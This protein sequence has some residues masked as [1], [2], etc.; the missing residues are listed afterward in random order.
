MGELDSSL[1][2]GQFLRLLVSVLGDVALAFHRG[3]KT[4][5]R[6]VGRIPLFSCAYFCIQHSGLLEK[7]RVRRTGIR[8]LTVTPESLS[9]GRSAKENES[10]NEVNHTL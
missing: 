4:D 2:L 7:F 6:H 1:L 9:S 3:L 10:M 5:F 8:Q